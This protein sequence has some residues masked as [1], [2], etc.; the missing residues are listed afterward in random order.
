MVNRD[1]TLK[2]IH[3]AIQEDLGKKITASE[4]LGEINRIFPIMEEVGILI[5]HDKSVKI[6]T[7]M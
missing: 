1:K 4:F 7:M 3:L 6:E 5:M 2:D